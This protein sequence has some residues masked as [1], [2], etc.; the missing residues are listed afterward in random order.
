MTICRN[1]AHIAISSM[2]GNDPPIQLNCKLTLSSISGY[3]YL[4]H[5]FFYAITTIASAVA[6]S[7]SMTDWILHCE[8][9]TFDIEAISCANVSCASGIASTILSS[10]VFGQLHS[11]FYHQNICSDS[12]SFVYQF[13]YLL[14]F[15]FTP[16]SFSIQLHYIIFYSQ[17]EQYWER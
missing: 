6:Y 12:L 1:I 5:P 3:T 9:S 4:C 11:I 17:Y 10:R 8:Q 7:P 13:F 16:T 15:A 2:P 14:C